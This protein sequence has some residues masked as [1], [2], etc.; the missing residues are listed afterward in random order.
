MVRVDAAG[1]HCIV[2]ACGHVMACPAEAIA[3]IHQSQPHLWVL[4]V[5]IV[6]RMVFMQ[7]PLLCAPNLLGVTAMPVPPRS[8]Q[9]LLLPHFVEHGAAACHACRDCIL[10]TSC[11]S[12]VHLEPHAQMPRR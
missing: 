4:A 12:K 10:A 2:L 7:L 1:S 11:V 9:H 5:A 6:P 8:Q 3:S